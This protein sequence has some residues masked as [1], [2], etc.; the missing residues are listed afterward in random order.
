MPVRCSPNHGFAPQTNWNILLPLS[1]LPEAIRF[2]LWHIGHLPSRR[3]V[4]LPEDVQSQLGIWKRL[5]DKGNTLECYFCKTCG[6]RVFHRSI[7][8]TGQSKPKLFVKD[9]LVEGLSW[10]SVKHIY[11]RSARVPVPEGS[12]LAAPEA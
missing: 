6:V 4:A 7:L 11:T 2:T 10:N 3:N 12:S 9:G 1:R 5:T 8:P